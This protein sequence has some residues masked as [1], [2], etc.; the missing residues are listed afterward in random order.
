MVRTVGVYDALDVPVEIRASEPL[1]SILTEVLADLPRLDRRTAGKV[2]LTARRHR[3]GDWSVWEDR[4]IR[5]DNTDAAS[6]LHV[7]FIC[8]NELV[9]RRAAAADAV[10]HAS[11]VEVNGQVVAFAGRGGAG[12]SRLAVWLALNGAGFVAEDVCA[13][14]SDA[15]VRPF[16]RPAG[17]HAEGAAELGIEVPDG[18]YGWLFP[19]RMG[20]RSSLSSGG[21]LGQIVL[22]RR[23]AEATEA[24]IERIPPPEALA[25]LSP[26]T[27]AAPGAEA[28]MFR[29]LDRLV[30]HVPVAELVYADVR[31]VSA[32]LW[33]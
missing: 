5:I 28:E 21:P 22:A 24:R 13:V 2:R 14:D 27:V 32:S 33:S 29:R 7:V 4:R 12:K 30:R 23:D 3:A 10:I 1:T 8:L 20:G 16:H 6:A 9:A 26:T 25:R 15:R 17:L 11:A 31:Q 18:P 19:Y